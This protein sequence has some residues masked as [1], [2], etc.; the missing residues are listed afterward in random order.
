LTGYTALNTLQWYH[1]AYVYDR[2]VSQQLVY[3]NGYLDGSRTTVS[4][5]TGN[6]SQIFLGAVPLFTWT[7]FQ[8]IFIDKLT[9]VSRVKNASE[10]LGEASLVAYYP[11]DSSY[12]DSGPNHINNSASVS[13][14][15][16]SARQSKQA[17]V[18]NSTNSS[19]FQTT[20]FYYLGQANYS[21]SFSLWIYPFVKN[22]TILQV[23]TSQ[24]SI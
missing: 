6:A 5:Y 19:Y 14:F 11:F 16:D 18:I 22:G 2:T 12:T 3:L 8:N 21:Y 4:P 24:K 9:F 20:G 13:T 23:I 15:F 10:H 17:L 7:I 1:V